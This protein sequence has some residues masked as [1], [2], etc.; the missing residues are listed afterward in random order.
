MSNDIIRS[1]DNAAEIEIFEPSG[2]FDEKRF[3]AVDRV[4][5]VMAG[6][7][8]IPNCLKGDTPEETYANCFLVANQAAGWNMDPFAVAQ[9]VS[10]IQ[11]K[12]CYEGKLIVAALDANLRIELFYHFEGDEGSEDFK[13]IVSDQE[14]SDD[15]RTPSSRVID[16]TVK[17][18][19]TYEYD[20]KSDGKRGE[21]KVS[22]NW[23]LNPKR[24]LRY[25]GAREWVRAF[26]PKVL[27]GAYGE[28][29]FDQIERQRR[30]E[31]A[32]DIT[33]AGSREAARAHKPFADEKN[34]DALDPGPGSSSQKTQ[35]KAAQADRA[36]E[37]S[38]VTPNASDSTAGAAQRPMAP[39]VPRKEYETLN[40]ELTRASN[41]DSLKKV[42]NKFFGG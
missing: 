28:D 25:R 22:Q 14:F 21:K 13:V 10:I 42:W 41:P 37:K 35:S 9:C 2:V 20:K 12:P 17:K 19:R 8:L 15:G 38:D 3:V 31:N 6:A 36:A 23:S 40:K 33:P 24:Q 29:E 5:R 18:W 4:A 16:G 39:A 34:Q 26:K 11:G 7:S 27:L 1:E 30:S 32:R